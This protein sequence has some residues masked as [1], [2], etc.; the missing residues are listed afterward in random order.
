TA[1]IYTPA[2]AFAGTVT[3]NYKAS[4][5]LSQSNAATVTVTVANRAPVA[6][7]DT[8]T[9]NK[10]VAVSIPVLAND[11]DPDG[12]ALSV[13]SL[14]QPANGSVV[15]GPN[16]TVTYT[17]KTGFAGTDSFTYK[18]S[19]GSSISNVATV[20]VTV[21]NRAPV[22]TGDSATTKQGKPVPIAVLANDTDPDGDSLRV[23][24]PTVPANGTAT[25]ANGVVTS[26]P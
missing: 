21:V 26:T 22:A 18:A 7:N 3:F 9:T 24:G 19:D 14:V 12:D 11:S 10:G 6:T 15:A 25:I 5:G 23:T 1:I 16:G 20:A 17:P 8:A 2:S 4:D 13:T